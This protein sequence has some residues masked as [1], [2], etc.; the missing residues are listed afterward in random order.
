[1]IKR[2][3]VDDIVEG[4][5]N[6]VFWKTFAINDIRAKYRRSKLGQFWIT[7]SVAAFILVIGI[8]YRGIFNANPHT[9]LAYLSVGYILWL[10]ISDVMV[11]G[12][13]IFTSNKAFLLQ[14]RM[15]ASV[16]AY[17]LVLREV[18]TFAHH[19]V[20]LPIIFLYL[21][22]WPGFGGLLL[23][24]IGFM[25]VIYCAFWLALILGIVSLRFRDMPPI[26]TSLTRLAFFATPIFWIERDLGSFGNLLL[27]FNPF[28]YAISVVRDPLLGSPVVVL[29][30]LVMVGLAIAVS[31]VG[32]VVLTKTRR[33]LTYWL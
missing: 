19:I 25:L 7:L 11:A 15:P 33:R 21:R 18:L 12:C 13:T 10:L 24:C 8:L 30:W 29:D 16:F 28:V 4:F 6:Y 27:V 1:M 22:L 3:A 26:V 31:L 20:I 2:F 9:Y 32:L 17:R 5:Q 23:S 14:R